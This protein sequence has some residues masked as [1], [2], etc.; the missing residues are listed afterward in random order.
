MKQKAR[1][2]I[3]IEGRVQG[4]FFRENTR[5]KADELG[6]FGWVRNL[7][8]GRV[9]IVFEG[10]KQKIEETIKWLKQGPKFAKVEKV[11]TKWEKP[12]DEFQNFEIRC[13]GNF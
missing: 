5:Q 3:F 9:E 10:K 8:D 1:A 7:P 6:I 4:V 2:H 11:N 13:N 12:K